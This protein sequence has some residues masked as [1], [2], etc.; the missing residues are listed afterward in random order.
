ME[1]LTFSLFLHV[2]LPTSLVV[3]CVMYHSFLSEVLSF[4]DGFGFLKSQLTGRVSLHSSFKLC[5]LFRMKTGFSGL[6]EGTVS[7]ERKDKIQCILLHSNLWLEQMKI[8]LLYHL[9]TIQDFVRGGGGE[10]PPKRTKQTNYKAFNF[11]DS[12]GFHK[13]LRAKY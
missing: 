11:T 1:A 5:P 10:H 7:P 6:I 4:A 9:N 12:A 13:L 3:A 8:Y 2:Y